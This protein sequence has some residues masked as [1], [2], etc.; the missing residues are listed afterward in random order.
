MRQ[1]LPSVGVEKGKFYTVNGRGARNLLILIGRLWYSICH[2]T[3]TL[4]PATMNLMTN[5]RKPGRHRGLPALCLVLLVTV[6]CGRRV[7][8]ST[9]SAVGQNLPFHAASQTNEG[10]GA[11]PAVPPDGRQANVA[12]F[13]AIPSSAV[14][15]AGTLLTVRLP[16]LLSANQVQPGDAFSA[17][18]ATPFTVAGKTLVERGA[19]VV[20]CIESVRLDDTN[21]QTP[22][23]YF[24]LTLK[25]IN[26]SGKDIAVQT[27]SLYTRAT[28]MASSI[29]SR[30]A[31]FRI[32]QGRH[33]TFRLTAPV[34]LESAVPSQ[35]PAGSIPSPVRLAE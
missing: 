16:H 23:G 12:P 7:S 17:S 30:P 33:L 15:P 5:D 9:G 29:P 21:P 4:Q 32:Q 13:H 6:G 10:E 20:G 11:V 2:L 19:P 34:A 25:S 26:I 8:D 18:V 24:R 35:P 3:S 28:V 31:T 22:R 27:L 14:L 1:G